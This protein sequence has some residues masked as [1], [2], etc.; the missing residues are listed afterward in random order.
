MA[1]RTNSLRSIGSGNSTPKTALR[2]AAPFPA[3]AT[4]LSRG[5]SPLQSRITE[6][7]VPQPQPD[8]RNSSQYRSRQLKESRKLSGSPPE[9]STACA[10]MIVCSV[11]SLIMPCPNR[12]RWRSGPGNRL[13]HRFRPRCSPGS[14]SESP[15]A[16]PN[17]SPVTRGSIE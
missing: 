11:S 1:S 7:S 4:P 3:D 9:E 17:S 6:R 15:A 13:S 5:E 12:K 16:V 2:I 14:P 10:A 8:G